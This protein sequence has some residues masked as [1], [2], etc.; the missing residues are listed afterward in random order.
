MATYLIKFKP[1]DPWFFGNEKAL[2]SPGRPLKAD[3]ESLILQEAK[4]FPHKAQSS[5]PCGI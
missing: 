5:E 2:L 1:I 3:T 4:R